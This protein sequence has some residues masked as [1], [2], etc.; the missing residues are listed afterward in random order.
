MI[1]T[2]LAVPRCTR[3]VDGDGPRGGDVVSTIGHEGATVAGCA[4]TERTV[5]TVV[6]R[7]DAMKSWLY[8]STGV[9][10]TLLPAV[11]LVGTRRGP[12]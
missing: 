4:P 3:D 1:D 11:E 6:V 5:C 12:W 8:W 9:A 2:A 7:A 10:V